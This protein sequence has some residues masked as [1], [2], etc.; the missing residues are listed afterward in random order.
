[1]EMRHKSFA[2]VV[3][4]LL[5]IV[6]Y[7]SSLINPA[8][9]TDP[10]LAYH[11]TGVAYTKGSSSGGD[12]TYTY[13]SNNVYHVSQAGLKRLYEYGYGWHWYNV[14]DMYYTVNVGKP[15]RALPNVAKIEV[16]GEA[17]TDMNTIGGNSV[18]FWILNYTASSWIPI[19]SFLGTTT[20]VLLS[21]TNTSNIQMQNFVDDQGNMKLRWN[22]ISDNDLGD[23]SELYVDYLCVKLTM[24]QFKWLFLVYLD[25]DW[26]R[27]IRDDMGRF[28]AWTGDENATGQINEM[29]SV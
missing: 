19:G 28:F 2:L 14:L 11:A 26:I 12:Y 5:L 8:K 13:T 1:M 23:F 29:E 22:F 17:K 15:G 18:Y 6:P 9:A 4:A 10:P 20:D 25:A 24:P 16:N 3:L 27:W 7:S 21:W